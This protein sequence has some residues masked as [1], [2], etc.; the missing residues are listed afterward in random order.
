M[1]LVP[2]SKKQMKV[3]CWW[4]K[5]SPYRKRNAVICDGAVRSGK[6]LCTGLSFVF[7]AMESFS[8]RSFAICGKTIRS[9]R[10]NLVTELVGT[11][12]EL[13]FVC[14]VKLSENRV[15]VSAGKVRNCFYL[16]GGRDESSQALIQGMTL[17]GVLFDEAALM[18]RS[19]VEQ[20][21]ARCSVEDAKYWFNCNPENPY[22]WFY[23]EWIQKL[24]EK[25][26]LYIHFRMEDN[27]SLSAEVRERYEK[28]FSGTFYQRFIEGK[29]VK[30]EG[31]VYPFMEGDMYYDVPEGLPEERCLSVDYGTVNPTSAGLWEKFGGVWYRTEEY[32][33]ASRL[34]EHRRTDEE[35]LEAILKMLRG[36][37][38]NR[39]VAD[40]SAASFMTLMARKGFSVVGADNDVLNGIRQVSGALKAGRIK[41]CRCCRD[42]IREF[43]LYC[44]NERGAGD[45]V[46]K[47]NDHAMDDIRYFVSTVLEN[48]GEGFAFAV[49]RNKEG[50]NNW[51]F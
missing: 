48:T 25:N 34:T 17:A 37:K 10:R 44:W 33:Y 50:G 27:P 2:F 6:T 21:L 47:E 5:G 7:W 18:P 51:D 14:E 35:H 13:G 31:L 49:P 23:L 38:V 1:R 22:H 19:F 45:A 28:L 43:G 24:K 16:F 39:V 41:I 29:W 46:Q 20:A 12:R 32:Y 9:I 15:D 30:A 3:M 26:A 36:R 42:S 8:S 40:P 11:L 4:C